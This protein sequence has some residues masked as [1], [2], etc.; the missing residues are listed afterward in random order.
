MAAPVPYTGLS[1]EA[2]APGTILPD[3]YDRIQATPADFGGQ[4]GQAISGPLDQG[5]QQVGQAASQIQN[6]Y[7]EAAGNQAYNQLL[8]KTTAISYGD[9][10]DPNSRGYKSLTGQDAL[11]GYQPA[12]DQLQ[13]ASQ[14]IRDGLANAQQQQEFDLQSRRLATY[15]A[16]EFG[17]HRAQQQDL[18]ANQT[19]DALTKTNQQA[20]IAA[21]GDDTTFTANLADGVNTIRATGLRNGL[22]GD[23]TQGQVNSYISQTWGGRI[24]RIADQNPQTAWNLYQANQGR[25]TGT[26]QLAMESRLRPAVLAWGSRNDA[27]TIMGGSGAPPG[28]SGP[29]MPAI[30]QEADQQGVGA[31]LA[32]TTAKLE[33]NTGQAPD[34]PGAA[35]SGVFQLT[36]G[37]WTARG[38]TA[39]NRGDVPT[40]IK[41]GVANLAHSQQVVS[42]ALGQ[43]AQDWQ[44]YMVH[45]QGDA[46]GAALLTAYPNAP[47]VEAL[48]PAY[49]GN[50]AAATAAITSNGGTAD[51]TAA[52]FLNSWKAKYA[53]ASQGVLSTA[54]AP[55]DVGSQ[56]AGWLKQASTITDP[57]G[58]DNPVYQDQVASRI[59]SRVGEVEYAQAQT[60]KANQ[61]TLLGAILGTPGSSGGAGAPGTGSVGSGG[62]P[63][64]SA[65]PTNLDQLLANPAAKAAWASSTP[66]TQRQVLGVL[67]RG[68]GPTGDAKTLGP[69]FSNTFQR[70]HLPDGDPNR[71]T[72]A[73]QLYP[74]VNQPGGLTMD[75]LAKARTEIAG[76]GTVDGEAESAM[77]VQFFKNARDQISQANDTL[78]MKDPQG[79]QNNL[80]FMAQAYTAIEAGKKQGLTAAQ[81]YGPDSPTYAGKSI[82]SFTRSAAQI[83]S[84]LHSANGMDAPPAAAP[85]GPGLFGRI[86][87]S[88]DDPAP[89]LSN[90]TSISA[91]YVAGRISRADAIKAMTGMPHPVASPA[92][93]DLS[94]AQVNPVPP[95]PG[96]P[97]SAIQVPTN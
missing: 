70:I 87:G 88:L 15:T 55:V 4:I 95:A 71:I 39:G 24:D 73:S 51:M 22:S 45:Q 50:T 7:N 65:P 56:A 37:T 28:S 36:P 69:A 5:V 31:T 14:Q 83:M 1:G 93:G 46:G 41:I 91:A 29:L 79:E 78:G 64:P 26:D 66:E 90:P 44:T 76:K 92:A 8:A 20:A 48:T 80:R 61:E 40:Q 6:V 94:T 49:G 10:N 23:V 53:T 72:D 96:Q 33:S 16:G 25:L 89:D 18:W 12:V 2:A 43:P 34:Q 85:S 21:S 11:N 9:P 74:M 35:A 63:G 47:A 32:L 42:S 13:Q 81:I 97:G 75:G 60:Q 58:Q 27:E 19:S 62:A 54:T 82:P 84:D 68:S 30:V 3:A 57:F 86:F 38:G 52:Q 17:Q 67:E 77:R 59:R